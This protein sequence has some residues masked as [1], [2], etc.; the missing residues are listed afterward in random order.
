MLSV[1]LSYNPYLQTAKLYVDEQPWKKGGDRLGSFVVDHPMEMWLS[2][3]VRGY[4]H[5]NGFLPELMS[6]L[7]E[8]VIALTFTGI[9]A[10]YT[11]FQ[12]ALETQCG[13]V[14]RSGYNASQW[15]V[16][17]TEFFLP[18]TLGPV[19]EKYLDTIAPQAPSQ[20]SSILFKLI[21]ES[22]QAEREYT[23]ESLRQKYKDICVALDDAI[24][25]CELSDQKKIHKWKKMSGD[26]N[27]I[28]RRGG[29]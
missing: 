7:N 13:L 4:L 11:R 16:K 25:Y 2:P 12:N 24:Q 3:Y 18:K 29:Y 23:V 6:E 26:F 20:N 19:L 22:F 9:A 1:N 8:D 28:M 14:E 10:D 27:T 17:H 15:K 21:R 5:W